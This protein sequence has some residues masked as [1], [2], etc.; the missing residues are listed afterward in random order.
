VAQAELGS[1]Y[2]F[3]GEYTNSVHRV[4]AFSAKTYGSSDDVQAFAHNPDRCWPLVGWKLKLLQPEVVCVRV[5]GIPIQFER[6]CFES[7]GSRELV[8]FGALVDG[9]PLPYRLDQYLSFGL[10]V[11]KT[12]RSGTIVRG[13]DFRFWGYV[14]HAFLSRRSLKGPKHFIRISTPLSSYPDLAS[15]DQTLQ[16]FLNDWLWPGDFHTEQHSSEHGVS[17]RNNAF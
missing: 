12:E 16:E 3:N 4:R 14:W 7:S 6:R 8:Y 9:E 10:T 17:E 13:S 11:N 5:A 1:D 15:A 2:F